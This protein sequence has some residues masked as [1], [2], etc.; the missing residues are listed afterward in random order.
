MFTYF[1]SAHGLPIAVQ[2][3]LS[4]RSRSSFYRK[5]LQP[6]K[7]AKMYAHI[8]KR[9][10]A[11]PFEGYKSIAGHL[12]EQLGYP[13]NPK[14]VYRLMRL[15]GIRA[16]SSRRKRQKNQY[17]SSKASL[18]N[19]LNEVSLSTPNQVWAGD[20]THF[21]Y[22]R[23]TYYLATVMDIYTRQ[24]VGWHV[25][26]HHSVE[27]VL[28]ALRMAM[29]TRSK[30]PTIFHSDHGSEYL[31]DE[32]LATLAL[33][34]ITP[35]NAAKGKPWQNGHV[36]SWNYRFKEELEDPNR[37]R[38]FEHLFEHFCSQIHHYNH[39]RIHSALK[40]TPDAFYEKSMKE[41]GA[42]VELQKAA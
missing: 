21:T 34:G 24:I 15:N 26:S 3:R 42:T 30:A 4:G 22:K 16:R 33:Y 31:S 35:S 27:L 6:E 41:L 23:R 9:H 17:V 19:R 2:A 29:G 12:S 20:F 8:L 32:Y 13:V 39:G 5:R 10:L 36:E 1:L 11:H 37:F 7:D 40:M 28:E 18:P 14:R 25:A 38:V